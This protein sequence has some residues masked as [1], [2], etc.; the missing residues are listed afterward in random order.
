MASLFFFFAALNTLAAQDK[1]PNSATLKQLDIQKSETS[2]EVYFTIEGEYSFQHFELDNPSR[3]VVEFPGAVSTI[4]PALSEV[5]DFGLNSIAVETETP[6]IVRIVFF[7]MENH[8]AYEILQTEAGVKVLF[9]SE[10]G[11]A[12]KVEETKAQIDIQKP[13]EKKSLLKSITYEKTEG[14]FKVLVAI[15][16]DFYRKATEFIIPEK[17]ILDLWPI[18][19]VSVLPSLVIQEPPLKDITVEKIEPETTRIVFNLGKDITSVQIVKVEAGLEVLFKTPE[20]PAVIKAAIPEPAVKEIVQK[21]EKPAYK[22]LENTLIGA[23]GGSYS[24]RSELFGQVYGKGGPIFG[25]ELTRIISSKNKLN[26]GL[27][28]EGRHYSK[29]GAS[30][31]TKEETKFSMLPLA[32][33]AKFLVNTK[34]FVPYIGIGLDYYKYKEESSIHKTSGSCFGYHVQGGTY[35]QF[36]RLEALKVKLY[37]KLTKAVA[38][39]NN[40]KTD[41]GGMEFGIGV[42]YGF[43][44]LNKLIFS[45]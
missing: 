12:P 39:E 3:L 9:R 15:E 5:N 4:S 6:E 37:I 23:Q 32:F 22:R 44:V 1:K 35:F 33:S 13:E 45:R 43:N 41:L 8:P 27:S 17:L 14:Q 36:P 25:L 10:T 21:K 20:K 26:F 34:L 7:L 42:A 40:T 24:I 31:I 11:E 2:L 19:A 38:T 29:T 16:G 28:F 30:T 18:E